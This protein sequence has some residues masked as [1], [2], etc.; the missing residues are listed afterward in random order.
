MGTDFDELDYSKTGKFCFFKRP[1]RE[2]GK[3]N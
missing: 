2:H 1:H 3:L